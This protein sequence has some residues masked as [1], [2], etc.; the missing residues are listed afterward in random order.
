MTGTSMTGMA[1]FFETGQN[2]ELLIPGDVS[3]TLLPL[4]GLRVLLE[5]LSAA[6]I[7]SFLR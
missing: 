6:V 5:L 2:H 3:I 7:T 1:A 4:L